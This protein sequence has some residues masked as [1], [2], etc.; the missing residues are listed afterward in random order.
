MYVR[1]SSPFLVLVSSEQKQEQIKL[2]MV[3][4]HF[5][6]VPFRYLYTESEMHQN[7]SNYF[8]AWGIKSY[9]LLLHFILRVR[10]PIISFHL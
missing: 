2:F 4:T 9:R 6:I 1:C 3:S 8:V 10:F 7:K 5:I